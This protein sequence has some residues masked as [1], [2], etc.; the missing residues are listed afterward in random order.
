M[1]VIANKKKTSM[2]AYY[3]T[4]KTVQTDF[5]YM[6]VYLTLFISH[7]LFVTLLT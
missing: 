4:L 5:K 3:I 6:Y 2:L 1:T 7:K